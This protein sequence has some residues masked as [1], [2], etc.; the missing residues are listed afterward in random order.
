MNIDYD[1]SHLLGYL[2]IIVTIMLGGWGIYVT[3]K[4]K[5]SV[6]VSFVL[7]KSIALFDTIVKNIT[8]LSVLYK[9]SPI[10][11]NLILIEGALVNTG[12]KDILPTMIE[13]P[14]SLNLPEDYKWLTAKIISISNNVEADINISDPTLTINSGL[15]KINEYIRFQ[16]LLQ[17]NHEENISKLE[18]KLNKIIK[19]SH[20]IADMQKIKNIKLISMPTKS[21]MFTI[22]MF[23]FTTIL[24]AYTG[25]DIAKEKPI[26]DTVYSFKRSN[27]EIINVVIKSVE[28]K[29][30]SIAGIDKPFNITISAEEFI[31]KGK[32]IGKKPIN[33]PYQKLSYIIFFIASICSLIILIG[34]WREYKINKKLITI[35]EL[36]Q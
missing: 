35:L 6:R 12:N 27:N 14:I 9:G 5:H 33:L 24:F 19:F 34:L 30:F 1:L 3:L 7:R 17:A 21:V 16:A 22:F 25:Y 31:K 23:L 32:M 28:G 4:Y 29:N 10:T 36:N 2:G 13:R 8:E 20:R 26:M 15:F 11:Q 18:N